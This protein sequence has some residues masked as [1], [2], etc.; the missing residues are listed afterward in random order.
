MSRRR[1]GL[2]INQAVSDYTGELCRGASEAAKEN[3]ADLYLFS[4]SLLDP[5][6][7]AA[8]NLTLFQH[9]V[10]YEYS[11]LLDLDAI[12]FAHDGVK[13]SSSVEDFD[14]LWKKVVSLRKPCVLMETNISG[15]RCIRSDQEESLRGM[16]DF[17]VEKQRFTKFGLITGPA[18]SPDSNLRVNCIR[19]RLTEKGLPVPADAIEQGSFMEEAGRLIGPL[20]TRHPETECVFCPNDQAAIIAIDT[21]RAMGRMPGEDI[22]IVGFDNVER[23]RQCNPPLTTVGQ[24]VYSVGFESM[25]E[26]LRELDGKPQETESIPCKK[27]IRASTGDAGDESEAGTLFGA[28]LP[29]T[30]DKTGAAAEVVARFA[31]GWAPSEREPLPIVPVI[32][33]CLDSA[34]DAAEGSRDAYSR[35]RMEKLVEAVN[36]G[37]ISASL[38]LEALIG[39]NRLLMGQIRDSACRNIFL[40]FTNLV[41][42]EFFRYQ[43]RG[44]KG[45]S[46][47]ISRNT[48]TAQKITDAAMTGSTVNQWFLNRAGQALLNMDIRNCGIFLF[49]EPVP[50]RDG[51]ERFVC[52]SEL[53][54][55]LKIE[56]GI[57]HYPDQNR[58]IPLGNILHEY[59]GDDTPRR[60]HIVFT[61]QNDSVQYGI[62]L[63]ESATGDYVSLFLAA[64]ELSSTFNFLQL[65]EQHHTLENKLNSAVDTISQK[66]EMLRE[67]SNFDPLTQILNRR[68]L[69]AKIN[70][71]V[72]QHRGET[73]VLLFLDLDN[74]K[75]INDGFGHNAG[76]YALTNFAQILRRSLRSDDVVGRFGGD[77]FMAL[78]LTNGF[79]TEEVI[80]RRIKN[81]LAKFN[82]GSEVPFYVEASIGMQ[83]FTCAEE[84]NLEKLF[85][86]ADTYL[87]K[88]KRRKRGNPAKLSK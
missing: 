2:L 34:F 39:F 32:R 79:Q 71:Q 84:L 13:Q 60:R 54:P 62:F 76:D 47:A 46:D 15:F 66:N 1:I 30:R 57:L 69:I 82:E 74:L 58:K 44:E 50:V 51:S 36:R 35:E 88:D 7:R 80:Y 45:R 5:A 83:T 29:F 31:H 23:A 42:T 78:C 21:A 81:A 85:D 64:S 12:I 52:G 18:E 56:D 77:E 27:V 43:M 17:L 4:G 73:A 40:E 11:L 41:L 37:E 65:E 26:A 63:C 72:E 75:G 19:E 6:I 53:N 3:N 86:S 67:I 33:E 14:R 28:L 68:G 38:L 9:N 70:E 8:E 20:L 16:V 59:A 55:V 24:D 22:A 61:L 48:F 10:I 49:P 87:Y 25:M